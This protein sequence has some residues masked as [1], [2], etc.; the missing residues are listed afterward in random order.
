MV[1]LGDNR[2]D[3][4]LSIVGE[5]YLA[6]EFCQ[7]VFHQLEKVLKLGQETNPDKLPS[8]DKM[9]E[10]VHKIYAATPTGD[11]LRQLLAKL[12]ASMSGQPCEPA[13][14]RN[15]YQRSSRYSP[16][17]PEYSAEGGSDPE[18][19][20]KEV[21]RK[22]VFSSEERMKLVEEGGGEFLCDV[23]GHCVAPRE[24]DLRKPK[25]SKMSEESKQLKEWF[26][27]LFGRFSSAADA[28][29]V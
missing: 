3:V 7:A 29:S 21:G 9:L 14:P 23:L 12:A 10:F 26:E 18:P 5:K 2:A 17:S 19:A 22:P 6:P 4:R 28:R 20:A 13:N 1:S 16:L 11:P 15:R 27:N 25:E 24:D 8:V